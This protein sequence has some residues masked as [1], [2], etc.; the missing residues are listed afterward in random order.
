M[1]TLGNQS[2]AS[3]FTISGS[4]GDVAG[5]NYTV[6]SPGIIVSQI[7]AV[8]S[9]NGTSGTGRLYVWE[10]SSGIPGSWLLRSGTF[11]MP[12]SQTT[13]NRTDISVNTSV[14]DSSGVIP[15]G[16]KIWIGYYSSSGV[17]EFWCA[18][19]SSGTELGNTADGNW[20]DH[21]A[22]SGIGQAA[23][24]ITYTL[25]G[26]IRVNQGTSGAPN[27]V[28][29]SQVATNTGTSG[30]PVWT[31]ATDA[32]VNTGTSVSPVWTSAT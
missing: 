27:F 1:S 8:I 22:A 4:F 23:A 31:V 11:T 25:T 16:T 26:I 5:G 20:S 30:T 32:A 28:A 15:G 29:A 7:S 18:S 14:L 12:A 3:F 17:S 19:G 21:G 9:N 24:W 2:T 6:P 13:E 10:D